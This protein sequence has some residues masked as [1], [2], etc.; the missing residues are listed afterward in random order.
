MFEFIKWLLLIGL[1]V[2]MLKAFNNLE[3]L[4][5]DSLYSWVTGCIAFIDFFILIII[6]IFS[7]YTLLSN[8]FPQE[9]SISMTVAIAVEFIY[10]LF[11]YGKVIPSYA[12]SSKAVP[13]NKKTIKL[14]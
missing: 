2:H 13:K 4:D 8:D 14:N 1:Y 10:L 6:G 11:I 12:N 9:L 7:I 3:E 5:E